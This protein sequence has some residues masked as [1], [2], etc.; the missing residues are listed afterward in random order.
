MNNNGNLLNENETLTKLTI[1]YGL[2]KSSQQFFT[3]PSELF[4]RNTCVHTPTAICIFSL[5]FENKFDQ[6]SEAHFN[7]RKSMSTNYLNTSLTPTS[8]LLPT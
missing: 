8:A 3:A 6:N 1:M 2:K 7:M 5:T 4:P